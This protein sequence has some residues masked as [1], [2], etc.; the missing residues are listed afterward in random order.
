MKNCF[1][2]IIVTEC[3]FIFSALQVCYLPLLVVG[4]NCYDNVVKSHQPSAFVCCIWCCCRSIEIFQAAHLLRVCVILVHKKLINCL[5]WHPQ[6]TAESESSLS[7]CRLWLASASN[8]SVIHV[9][10]LEKSLS[11]GDVN[12]HNAI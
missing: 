3:F 12:C 9:Y 8:E 4:V 7:P 6:Y 2:F 1:C 10:N 5:R 11:N